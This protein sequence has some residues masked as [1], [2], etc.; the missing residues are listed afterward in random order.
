MNAPGMVLGE[1]A[2]ALSA[3]AASR[4]DFEPTPTRLFNRTRVP[5]N[6]T[7]VASNSPA[8]KAISETLMAIATETTILEDW[9][10]GAGEPGC[11][12]FLKSTRGHAFACV[13]KALAIYES[14]AELDQE[15]GFG[16]DELG[17]RAQAAR[18]FFAGD[19]D[20][21]A[22]RLDMLCASVRGV[23]ADM[24][25]VPLTPAHG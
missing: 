6:E 7:I 20:A 18:H 14:T 13:D 22:A 16:L 9:A 4:G 24:Q 2:A 11:A 8:L 5:M 10:I 25:Q 3:E 17:F 21:I 12:S 23:M 19:D 15:L 1:R